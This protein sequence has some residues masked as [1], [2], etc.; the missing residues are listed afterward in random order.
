MLVNVSFLAGCSLHTP[1]AKYAR[2]DS[3]DPAKPPSVYAL[4]AGIVEAGL[5]ENPF[6]SIEIVDHPPV[7]TAAFDPLP[8]KVQAI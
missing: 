2:L 4:R 5:A 7:T 6:Q 3:T 1:T 8:P